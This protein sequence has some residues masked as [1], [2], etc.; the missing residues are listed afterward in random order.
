M[1][2]SR[3]GPCAYNEPRY[4]ERSDATDSVLVSR[5]A[6]ARKVNSVYQITSLDKGFEAGPLKKTG[7]VGFRMQTYAR[8]DIN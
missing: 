5:S 1:D 4:R 8:A 3:E 6:A 7:Y 2:S